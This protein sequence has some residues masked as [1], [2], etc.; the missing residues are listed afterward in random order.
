MARTCG[1]RREPYRRHQDFWPHCLLGGLWELLARETGE[2]LSGIAF[3]AFVL[4]MVISHVAEA[5][6]S[7]DYGITTLIAAL[8]TFVLGALA[9]RGNAAIDLA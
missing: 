3:L 7:K 6:V 2:V 9:L 8:I 4:L 1:R 5:R